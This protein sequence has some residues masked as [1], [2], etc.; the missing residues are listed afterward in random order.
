VARTL[1]H[2]ITSLTRSVS[3]H[4]LVG[5]ICPRC[6]FSPPRPNLVSLHSADQDVHYGSPTATFAAVCFESGRDRGKLAPTSVWELCWSLGAAPISIG[7]AYVLPWKII[8]IS[9]SRPPK[10]V[11]LKQ[12]QKPAKTAYYPLFPKTSQLC[13]KTSWHMPL[14]DSICLLRR[15]REGPCLCKLHGSRSA[16][17]LPSLSPGSGHV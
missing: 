2:F 15:R 16:S 7:P 3:I 1:L 14:Q 6:S 13:D 17:R 9:V 10:S 11:P 12:L 8:D 5:G 4:V